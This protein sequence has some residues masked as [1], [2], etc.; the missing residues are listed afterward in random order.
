MDSIPWIQYPLRPMKTA[1]V[2]ALS[3]FS[4]LPAC[5][6]LSQSSFEFKNRNTLRGVDAPVFDAQGIPLAGTNY[7]A[8]LWG[9]TTVDSLQPALNIDQ[10][11]Q[12]LIIPFWNVPPGYFSSSVGFLSIVTVPPNGWAWLQV[13]AW[14]ARLGSTY[15]AVAALGSGGYGESPLFYAQGADPL[16]EPPE[17]AAPLIGLQSFS[18][19]AVVPEPSSWLLLTLATGALWWVKRGRARR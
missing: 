11:N 3:A 16:R 4:L 6:V 18:L 7:S 10:G 14:D 5:T 2:V 1:I 17:P 15:E 9:G 12:R 8:E 19:R 13:R